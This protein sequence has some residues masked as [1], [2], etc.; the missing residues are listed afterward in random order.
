MFSLATAITTTIV[1]T[2][3]IQ[4]DCNLAVRWILVL[5]YLSVATASLLIA[6]RAIAI[7][8]RNKYVIAAVAVTYLTDIGWMIY[9]IVPGIVMDWDPIARACIAFN[10]STRRPANIG[11]FACDVCLLIVM[12]T[13]LWRHRG[14]GSLATLIKRQ[15]VVW[16]MIA[17]AFYVPEVRK[18]L[19]LF[20]ILDFNDPMNLMLQIPVGEHLIAKYDWTDA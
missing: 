14:S 3:T 1:M 6:L 7:W 4:I 9:G 13:G 2:A 20:V 16:F 11:V 15:G 19:Q 5:G 10:T 8:Y 18:K 17:L 12:L